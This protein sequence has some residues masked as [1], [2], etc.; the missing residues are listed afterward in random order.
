MQTATKTRRIIAPSACP[1]L[2]LAP[3]RL[4]VPR[5]TLSL[6]RSYPRLTEVNRSYLKTDA[7]RTYPRLTEANRTKIEFSQISAPWHFHFLCRHLLDVP[8][9]AV[10]SEPQEELLCPLHNFL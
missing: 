4:R 2:G 6:I 10:H 3:D 7:I 5:F 9:P 8:K 1:S